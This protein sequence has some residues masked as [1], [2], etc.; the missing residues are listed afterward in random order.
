MSTAR[1]GIELDLMGGEEALRTVEQLEA[2]LKSLAGSAFRIKAKNDIKSLKRELDRIE[3]DKA[4]VRVET[5]SAEQNI[6]RL[7]QE[8]KSLERVLKTGQRANGTILSNSELT[9]ARNQLRSVRQEIER[10]QGVKLNLGAQFNSLEAEAKSAR[11]QIRLTREALQNV[12][13]I[14]QIFT[15]AT[16][17]VSHLGSAFQSLGSAMNR[18]YEPVRWLLNGTIFAAGY[19][20]MNTFSEGIS[21]GFSRYD[22][23]KKYPLMMQEYSKS[24]Y[25]ATDSIKEL[26]MSVRGLPTGLDEIVQM[27]QRYTL[28]LGDMKRGTQLAI[29]SNNAFLASMATDSQKYQ[30]MMQLQD[31]MNGKKLTSREW[32][33]LGASM[34][35]AINEVGKEFGYTNENM[36][37]FRQQLY[38]SK[39]DSKDFLD[40]LIKVGTGTGKVAKMAELS[41]QTWEAFA[42]NVRN[43]F[44]RMTAGV[45]ES[46]DEV[47][48]VATG[49][50]YKSAN[51]LLIDKIIPQ[52]D[53]FAQAAKNWIKANP[54][55]F[56]DTINRIKALDWKGLAKGFGEGMK[57]A[58]DW[59]LKLGEIM[60]K[61]GMERIGKFMALS[62]MIANGLTIIGG[63]LRGGRFAFGASAVGI[64]MLLRALTGGGIGG[65]AFGKLKDMFKGITGIGKDAKAAEKATKG[66][67][68]KNIKGSLARWVKPLAGIGSVLAIIA[69]VA[70]TI[71]ISTKAI[72]E[73]IKDMRQ[74]SDDFGMVDWGT[75][76][77]VG[78]GF[79]AFVGGFTGLGKL[80]SKN[81]KGSAMTGLGTAIVG[82]ITSMVAGF[83]RLDIKLVKDSIK[84][85]VTITNDAQ[86]L[87][88]NV[89]TLKGIKFD[90]GSVKNLVSQLYGVYQAMFNRG[91][92]SLSEIKPRNTKKAEDALNSLKGVFN[93]VLGITT[94]LP[95]M[96]DA[97]N[98]ASIQ[99]SETT[100]RGA[101]PFTNFTTQ[102]K[103][104]FKGVNEILTSLTT[105]LL[106]EGQFSTKSI[107]NFQAIMAS[108]KT[109][110]DSINGIMTTLPTLYDKMSSMGM[111]ARGK[112]RNGQGGGTFD[113]LLQ[114]MK[115]LFK[116]IGDMYRNLNTNI[117]GLNIEGLEGKLESVANGM[118]SIGKIVGK[119]K[120]LG[121]KGGGL[122]TADG[123]VFNAIGN[124]KSMIGSL[125]SALGGEDLGGLK[126]AIETFVTSVKSLLT[127]LDNI[128]GVGNVV[129]VTITIKG[130]VKENVTKKIKEAMNKIKR[131]CRSQTFTKHVHINIQRHVS[132]GGDSIPSASSIA[133]NTG[134][135]GGGG[136]GGGWHH[137]GY[138]GNGKTLYRAKGGSV[139][140]PKGTDTI[141]AMLTHGE[142]VQKKSAVDFW[143]VRFMQKI[144]NLDINGAM[145]ELSARA[146]HYVNANRGTTINNNTT[147]NTDFTQNV[148]TSNP[149]FAFKRSSRYVGAL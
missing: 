92:E 76:A 62:G 126:T 87:A 37:E 34:G 51:M 47:V 8:A 41:K 4:V 120:S 109:M 43:A 142:F 3:G 143:G 137:G 134:G 14:G 147:N 15:S 110:F 127:Q 136:G 128:A 88:S 2:E 9:Q 132:I 38:G 69:G 117:G 5:K 122:A 24:A 144:N 97:M 95:K 27:A 6:R 39:I 101:T 26:D 111:H 119:L 40:A 125:K 1:V 31:L 130:T 104:L 12:K 21:A 67:A 57:T 108:V 16:S 86:T 50:K 23:M 118:A 68:M 139:F 46:M 52:I 65:K 42:A 121:G 49:G 54:D 145:R 103:A 7:K 17:K 94:L 129:D 20:A 146:S 72:K 29:A 83:G 93:A 70:G 112:G 53:K 141:P 19:K 58:L 116:G 85:M 84:D 60:S 91:G 77:K 30:G 33:S 82:G 73:A 98:N 36:G 28:S 148:Y 66:S 18:V 74:I 45:V 71:M 81:L 133:G 63:A 100:G 113:T 96:Y 89:N 11:E 123:A 149:N 102:V 10:L 78:T 35:K 59:M 135:G 106:G 32:M 138:I 25:T 64:V 75:M 99:G 48:R 80:A 107:G 55:F 79:A 124:I 114:S 61:A 115:S 131:A 56:I 140:K 105:D 13:P 22:I 44:S 90:M